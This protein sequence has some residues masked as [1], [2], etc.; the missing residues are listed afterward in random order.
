M[1]RVVQGD[2]SNHTAFRESVPGHDR[3]FMVTHFYGPFDVKQ[4]KIEYAKIAYAAGVK[5]IVDISATAVGF[6]W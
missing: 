6:G 2:Y 3:L 1:L 4:L 5:Q